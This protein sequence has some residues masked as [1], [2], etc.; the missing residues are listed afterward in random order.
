MS[1]VQQMHEYKVHDYI[2]IQQ[3]IKHHC[4]KSGHICL[5]Q[6]TVTLDKVCTHTLTPNGGSHTHSPDDRLAYIRSRVRGSII[7]TH[8]HLQYTEEQLSSWRGYV[9]HLDIQSTINDNFSSS[10]LCVLRRRFVIQAKLAR[11][12][13]WFARWSHLQGLMKEKGRN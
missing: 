7:S 12:V 9:K 3:N 5:H 4:R 2:L 13:L 8:S 6:Q 1:D 11:W 10:L